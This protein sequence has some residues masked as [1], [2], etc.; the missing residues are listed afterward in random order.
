MAR[1]SFQLK[2][3][4]IALSSAAI[5]LLVAGLLM[6][7]T[8]RRDANERLEGTLIEEAKLAAELLRV[9]AQLDHPDA[10]A[11]RMGELIKQ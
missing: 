3:F 1:G 5:A 11:D 6:A 4:L 8:M 10:E 7:A 9:A 2:L